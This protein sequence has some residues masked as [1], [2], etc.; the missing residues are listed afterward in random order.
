MNIYRS[1][2]LGQVDLETFIIQEYFVTEWTLTA[3]GIFK[4][5]ISNTVKIYGA[6]ERE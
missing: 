1:V 2:I 6:H 4:C 3:D 5:E